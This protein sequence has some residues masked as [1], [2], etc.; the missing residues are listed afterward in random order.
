MLNHRYVQSDNVNFY[1]LL[2]EMDRI[3]FYKRLII[4][5]LE[6]IKS[7]VSELE[8][9]ENI[10][11]TFVSI[12]EVSFLFDN[13]MKSE[14]SNEHKRYNHLFEKYLEEKKQ[15]FRKKGKRDTKI[16]NEARNMLAINDIL[17]FLKNY[18]YDKV[19]SKIE[20]EIRKS[21]SIDSAFIDNFL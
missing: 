12:R 1:S 5:I 13:D 18:N 20:A 3:S 11:D 15:F 9:L 14:F 8:E 2:G 21:E 17:P 16:F 4:P 19:I 6:S 7:K 10:I